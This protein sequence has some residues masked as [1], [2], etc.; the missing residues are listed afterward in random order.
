MGYKGIEEE[1]LKGDRFAWIGAAVKWRTHFNEVKASFPPAIV[2]HS[3]LGSMYL[4]K[5]PFYVGCPTTYSCHVDSVQF[6]SK[7]EANRTEY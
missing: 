3:V 6:A 4:K 7:F 5:F 2:V 1:G